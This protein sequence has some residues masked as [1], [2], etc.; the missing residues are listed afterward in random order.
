MKAIRVN[1]FGGP[2]V[3]NL[4][5]IPKP[6]PSAGEVLIEV[7]AIGVNPVETYIR[8]GA[9]PKLKLPYTPGSDAVGAI[10][11]LGEG[12]SNLATG[13]RVYTSETITGAYAEFAVAKQTAVHRLPEKISFTQGAA[14]NVPYATA[15]R[16]LFQRARAHI[17]EFVLIHGASGGVGLAA[18][19]WGKAAGLQIIGT[20][21]SDEGRIVVHNEGAQHVL[22]HRQTGYLDQL[23]QLTNGRG[24]DVII[25]MLSNINLSHDLTVLAPRGRVVIVGS[26]GKVEINP[27]DTMTREADILGLML[28]SASAEDLREIHTSIYRGLSEGFLRPIIGREFPLAEAAKAHTAIMES[29]ARGKIVLLP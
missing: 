14:V 7:H 1:Q 25:E 2:E 26:R 15:Y 9:N 27:R 17:G 4:E 22:D 12:V 5:E 6:Q 21:G 29:G 19:Q 20:A 28:F 8:G 10:A 3:L 18:V 16:A 11:A 13:D 23:L 24:V